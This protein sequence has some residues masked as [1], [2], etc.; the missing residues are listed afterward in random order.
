MRNSTNSTPPRLAVPRRGHP[1]EQQTEETRTPA[2]HGAIRE[3]TTE[4]P[5]PTTRVSLSG[6][7]RQRCRAV[8]VGPYF[9]LMD[10]SPLGDATQRAARHLLTLDSQSRRPGLTTK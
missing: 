8:D 4:T 5:P 1:Q 10:S 6:R 2:K 9:N 3:T 7:D